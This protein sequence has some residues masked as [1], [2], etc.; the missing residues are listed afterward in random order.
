M[1]LPDRMERKGGRKA[2]EQQE[3]TKLVLLLVLASRNGL[4]T[5]QQ[6]RL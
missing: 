5:L 4:L 6:K 2:L 1:Q 3:L